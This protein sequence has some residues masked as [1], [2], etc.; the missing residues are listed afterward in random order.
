MMTPIWKEEL[1]KYLV[2]VFKNSIDGV[3][4]RYGENTTVFIEHE[5]PDSISIYYS[6]KYIIDSNGNYYP[7]GEKI[8]YTEIDVSQYNRKANEK[9]RL[10]QN[11]Y[12]IND[13]IK[14][15]YSKRRRLI[16]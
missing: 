5:K 2:D 15:F 4:L 1:R 11:S 9:I 12:A 10:V 13:V 8:L 6:R 7:A 14:M 3:R 16:C